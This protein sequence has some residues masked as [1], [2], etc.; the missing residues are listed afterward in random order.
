MLQKRMECFRLLFDH[1]TWI[2]HQFLSDIRDSRKAGN[3]WGMMRGVGG[4]RKSIYQSWL[5]KRLGLG[6]LCWGLKGV[7]Q[8]IPSGEASTLQIGSA[9]FPPGQYTSPQ[10]QSLLQTIWRRWTLRQFLS[11]PIVQTLVPVTFGHSLSSEAVVLR[12]LSRWKRLWRRTLTRS[13]KKTPMGPSRSCWNGT[14]SV[15]QPEYIT[16][17]GTRVPCVYYQSQCPYEKKSLGTYW[18]H[19]VDI[20]IE[21]WNENTIVPVRVG[22]LFRHLGEKFSQCHHKMCKNDFRFL[23]FKITKWYQEN[24]PKNYMGHI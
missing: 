23:C 2:E 17:K 9:T 13:H 15:L 3:L 21:N 6:L 24:S 12:Q 1:L 10:L 4:V 16:S 20:S 18:R 5:V 11:L 7:Q 8:E 19:L 22:I 14:T